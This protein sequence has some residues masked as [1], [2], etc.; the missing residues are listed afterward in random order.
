MLTRSTALRPFRTPTPLRKIDGMLWSQTT[1]SFI[2]MTH[3]ILTQTITRATR[4][5]LEIL[6][7]PATHITPA[8]PTIP[9]IHILIRATILKIRIIML[10]RRITIFRRTI[11]QEPR[12]RQLIQCMLW[13][14]R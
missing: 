4:T 11:T 1:T 10:G 8:I 9:A 12:M 6:T 2:H 3:T 5:I 7:I 13:A 14:F